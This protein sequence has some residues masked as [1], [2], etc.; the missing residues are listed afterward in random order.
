VSERDDAQSARDVA[1][2][3]LFATP[4]G[5]V[6]AAA[7]VRDA[8]DHAGNM[9]ED[10]SE[11]N[12]PNAPDVARTGQATGA[13]GGYGTASG[14]GSSSGSGEATDETSNAGDDDQTN[15]LRDAPGAG[16]DR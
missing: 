12:E 10:S 7:S 3:E 16:G 1:S 9:D 8:G 4:S 11:T 14:L 5:A 15:W 2:S 6:G 13:S